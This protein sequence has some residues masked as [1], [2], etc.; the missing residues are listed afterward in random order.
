MAGMFCRKAE[1]KMTEEE[2]PSV[3]FA[4][5]SIWFMGLSGKLFNNF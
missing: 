3:I 2:H 4:L 5:C 1:K